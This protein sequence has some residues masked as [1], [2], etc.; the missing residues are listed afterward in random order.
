[1]YMHYIVHLY[2]E[3]CLIQD[4]FTPISFICFDGFNNGNFFHQY[5]EA[6]YP[7]CMSTQI[8]KTTQQHMYNSNLALCVLTTQQ[9]TD[10]CVFSK[11]VVKLQIKG[12]LL[13]SLT[14]NR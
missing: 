8:K 7:E 6:S 5:L 4:P 1:M 11:C 9:I 14:C 3:E 12:K 10:K 2:L 13:A